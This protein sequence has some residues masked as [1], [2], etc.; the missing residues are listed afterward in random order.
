MVEI[1]PFYIDLKEHNE[2]EGPPQFA[3]VASHACQL[4]WGTRVL[5]SLGH[6]GW[7]FLNEQRLQEIQFVPIVLQ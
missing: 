1:A 6:S 5:V 2:D 7:H 3:S 4:V